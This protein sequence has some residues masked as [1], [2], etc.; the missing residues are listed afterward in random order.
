M[1]ISFSTQ[2]VHPR[3]RGDYWQDVMTEVL[4]AH[5][6]KA[7]ATVQA[8]VSAIEFGPITITNYALTAGEVRRLQQHARSD[9]ID[10][11]H[12]TLMR[13]G[14]AAIS[15]EGRTAECRRD[16]LTLLDTSKPHDTAFRADTEAV[17]FSLPR[18][19]L[20][21]R[22]GKLSDYLACLFPEDDAMTRLATNFAA[23]LATSAE[24]IDPLLA[25]KVTEH[26]LD[27][28]ALAISRSG[29]RNLSS[30][31]ASS[32]AR[33]KA[34]IAVHLS[35][36][37]MTATDACVLA[38]ISPRYANALLAAEGTSVGRYLL[39]TRLDR[40]RQSFEDP[41]QRQR[42]ISEVAFGWGFTDPSHFARCFKE[43]YGLAPREY[44][45]LSLDPQVAATTVRGK[46]ST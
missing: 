16:S 10:E 45:H 26:F 27:L 7:T 46:R 29:K 32:L 42:S 6:F 35:D 19:L 24:Q 31:R 34:A 5:D 4:L 37:D 20:E 39:A 8:S 23:T 30:A 38:G 14:Y 21:A 15:Q 22:V 18:Q 33:L 28:I 9:D 2:N 1:K 13:N 12:L 11:I 44:R 25:S 36:P 43:K 17:C 3:D 40:A 41:A